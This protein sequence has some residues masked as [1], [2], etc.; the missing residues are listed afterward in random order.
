LSWIT[1][2]FTGV[3]NGS[4]FLLLVVILKYPLCLQL[5]LSL[6]QQRSF[7]DLDYKIRHKFLKAL[8]KYILDHMQRYGVSLSSNMFA[9]G[10]AHALGITKVSI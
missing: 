9:C 6:P 1:R 8:A 2:F 4:T 5:F 7:T 3:C 10:N